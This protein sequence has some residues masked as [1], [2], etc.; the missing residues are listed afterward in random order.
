MRTGADTAG[1][2]HKHALYV[3]DRIYTAFNGTPLSS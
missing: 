3:R 2:E 1:Q